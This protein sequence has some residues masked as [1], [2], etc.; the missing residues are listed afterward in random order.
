MHLKNFAHF[1]ADS[2]NEKFRLDAE[3]NVVN[4]RNEMYYINFY[5]QQHPAE[6]EI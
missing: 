3:Y 2:D 4:E 5:T 6:R 1:V